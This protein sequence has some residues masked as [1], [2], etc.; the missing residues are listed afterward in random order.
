MAFSVLI[1]YERVIVLVMDAV[2]YHL[3]ASVSHRSFRPALQ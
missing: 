3:R 1:E 2:T